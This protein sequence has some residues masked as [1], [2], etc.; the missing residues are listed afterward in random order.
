MQ[1]RPVVAVTLGDPSGI[2]PEL[3]ARLLARPETMQSANVVLV[4][5]PWLWELGQRH[6]G[7]AV[8]VQEVKRFDEV[9]T[10]LEQ[11]RPAFLP[12]NSVRPEEVTIA[13]AAASGGKSV[14]AVLNACL[15]AALAS[16]IDA[17]CFAP[18]NKQAMKMGGLRHED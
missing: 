17:I 8:P 16:Y 6:A 15:E 4:G 2:G 18:L 5:D 11:A 9:R 7:V 1:P 12:L 13:V 10:R 14:L 3:V